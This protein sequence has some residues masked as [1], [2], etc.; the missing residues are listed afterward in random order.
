MTFEL[1][2]DLSEAAHGTFNSLVAL[3][4]LYQ[5][6]MGIT[7]RRGRKRGEPRFVAI[8]RH[9]KFGPF[10][11]VMGL[12]GYCFGLILVWI[13]KG[14]VLVYPLHLALGSLIVIFLLGQYAVS[15]RIKGL[16][17]PWRTP[18]LA[19]GVTILCLYALQI[20]VGLAVLF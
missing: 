18:H 15:R 13:D 8:K 19:I 20:A 9:R 1:F 16:E 17:S 10:L 12:L 2:I 14:R 7:I 11:V 4:L 6:W 3:C 5:A